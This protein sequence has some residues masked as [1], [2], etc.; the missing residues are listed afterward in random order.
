L[1]VSLPDPRIDERSLLVPSQASPN[2]VSSRRSVLAGH[3]EV[4][5]R[6]FFVVVHASKNPQ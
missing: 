3:D 1:V 2:L 6:C 5:V 4:N